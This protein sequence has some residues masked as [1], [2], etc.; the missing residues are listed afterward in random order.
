MPGTALK[1]WGARLLLLAVSLVVAAVAMEVGL[2]IFEVEYPVLD[3]SDPYTGAALRPGA[4]GW[5]RQEG[6]AYIQ[7]NSA[8]L[9]DREH[10]RACPP[11]TYRIAVLGDSYAEAFQL[12]IENT[13]W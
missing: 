1:A 9:R 7:I 11:N 10:P 4:H 3:Q 13:F 12:A 2:R 5:W 6:E 8:G